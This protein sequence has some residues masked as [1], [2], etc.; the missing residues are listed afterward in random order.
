MLALNILHKFVVAIANKFTFVQINLNNLLPLVYSPS[1][2]TI[3]NLVSAFLIRV[4]VQIQ[5]RQPGVILLS[6][7]LTELT[8]Q[9][10]NRINFKG[11]RQIIDCVVRN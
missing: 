6:K 8:Q 1:L 7:M 5:T 2:H 4:I 10:I 3:F 9:S 11:D